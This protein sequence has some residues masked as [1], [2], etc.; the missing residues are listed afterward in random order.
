MSATVEVLLGTPAQIELSGSST[1]LVAGY[2]LQL[3]TTTQASTVLVLQPDAP[4]I[5]EVGVAPL[6]IHT[7][8][9]LLVS[10][11]RFV[12]P[13]MPLGDVVWNKALVYLDLTED[14]LDDT[15]SLRGDRDYAVEEHVVRT[16]GRVV[17]FV[18]TAPDGLHAVVS[19]LGT[20]YD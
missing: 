13:S 18:S 1:G 3:H 5:I 19:Y 17:H 6:R 11:G 2:S 8:R 12:L 15:G 20:A 16:E 9:P 7:T 4:H 14:D 10:D